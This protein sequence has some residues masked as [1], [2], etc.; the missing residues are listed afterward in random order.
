MRAP[1]RKACKVEANAARAETENVSVGIVIE[2]RRI[3]FPLNGRQAIDLIYGSPAAM[4]T[5]QERDCVF[6]FRGL[7]VSRAPGHFTKVDL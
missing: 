5:A 4:L 3:D 7:D 6:T 2:N 1:F